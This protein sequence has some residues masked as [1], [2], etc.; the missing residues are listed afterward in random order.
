MY[1]CMYIY[2]YIYIY[3]YIYIL[4]LRFSALAGRRLFL[5]GSTLPPKKARLPPS[6]IWSP[7]LQRF[8][9]ANFRVSTHS[10]YARTS[11]GGGGSP[12]EKQGYELVFQ[13]LSS[14]R[15]TCP[16]LRS[17]ANKCTLATAAASA[18]AT[19]QKPNKLALHSDFI[20]ISFETR[21]SQVRFHHQTPI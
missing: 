6:L 11:Q 3:I 8:Y 13:V 21:H 20:R 4:F 12:H 9:F 5:C 18:T 19:E 2:A 17:E 15:L 1:V 16:W 10:R 7:D 14:S